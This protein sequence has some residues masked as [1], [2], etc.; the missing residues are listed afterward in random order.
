MTAYDASFGLPVAFAPEVVSD[1]LGE[2]YSRA[3]LRQ[4][5]LAETEKYAHVT[6]FLNCGREEPFPGE[7]RRLVPS[8]RDVA[9]YDL[10]PEMSAAAV[11]DTFLAELATGGYSLAVVNLANL[12]M[13]VIPG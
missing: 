1:V 8:P 7:E 5:R 4:L 6:Y 2:V 11:T 12:D 9:T 10:K 3:G 13:P